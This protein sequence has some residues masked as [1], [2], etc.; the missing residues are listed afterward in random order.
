MCGVDIQ[1]YVPSFVCLFKWLLHCALDVQVS[2][3]YFLFL[4]ERLEKPLIDWH[5]K[6]PSYIYSVD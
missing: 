6:S 1:S 2:R 5:I 4:K 3:G